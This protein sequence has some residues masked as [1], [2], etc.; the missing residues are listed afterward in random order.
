MKSRA[1]FLFLLLVLTAC[2]NQAERQIIGKW[3]AAQLQECDDLVPIQ[4]ELVNFEFTKNGKYTFN[5]TLNVHED[6]VFRIKK[7]Y[8]FTKNETNHAAAEKVVLIQSLTN[9][10]LVLAMNYKGK[11]QLLTLIREGSAEKLRQKAEENAQKQAVAIASGT[12]VGVATVAINTSP[13]A[14]DSLKKIAA[15]K[16]ADSLKTKAADLKK[17]AAEM[18]KTKEKEADKKSDKFKK[19]L[20]PSEAYKKREAARQKEEKERKE[21]D[22]KRAE[23]YKKREA[24][25]EKE[26]R[27]SHKK[28]K[29]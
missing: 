9:D 1:K 28:K 29:K 19:D 7:N 8:L 10:S 16:A 23:A 12:A 13:K 24:Q 27:E 21:A 11:D 20:T 18:E 22:K 3:Q 14:V 17:A 6:G 25:R 15:A 26:E 2:R 4:T 5:S